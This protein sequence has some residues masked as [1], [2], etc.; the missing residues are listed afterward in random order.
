MEKLSE[1][2]AEYMG[3]TKSNKSQES[4]AIHSGVLKEFKNQT[5]EIRC[6]TFHFNYLY[7]RL[8]I[9]SL[10]VPNKNNRKEPALSCKE[11]PASQTS[12]GD[13]KPGNRRISVD[14]VQLHFQMIPLK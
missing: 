8:Y 5:V 9:L 7:M 13:Q 14:I 1:A 10:Q 6:V 12:A 11:S 3:N 2:A 4:N